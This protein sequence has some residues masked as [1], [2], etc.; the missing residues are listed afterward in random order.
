MAEHDPTQTET[1]AAGG[2][3]ETYKTTN[4]G[5][6]LTRY[7]PRNFDE[8][9]RL[10]NAVVRS[11]LAPSS[12]NRAEDAMIILMSGAELG[13]TAMQ[14]LRSI[15]VIKGRP[16]LSADLMVALVRR[17]PS[18]EF[19][20]LIELTNDRCVYETKRVEARTSVT[21][22]FS[23]DDA[24]RAG[25]LNNDNWKK[26]PRNMLRARCASSLARAEYPE[27]LTGVYDPDELAEPAAP[28]NTRPAR[29]T[30]APR[31]EDAIDAE[32]E[33]VDNAQPSEEHA[34]PKPAPVDH[35]GDEHWQQA[36]RRLHALLSHCGLGKDAP[37]RV[38]EM[39]KGTMGVE[40]FNH[41]APNYLG[42]VVGKLSKLSGDE[43]P[44]GELS[45]RAAHVIAALQKFDGQRPPAPEP[46]PEL[47]NED[48]EAVEVS[49]EE[50]NAVL[51]EPPAAA[52][53]SN[54]EARAT[55]EEIADL[56]DEVVFKRDGM[57]FLDAIA[58]NSGVDDWRN[59]SAAAAGRYRDMLHGLGTEPP[60][61]SR[62]GT[63]SP[64]AKYIHDIID[65]QAN[66]NRRAS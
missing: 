50:L 32:F 36:N 12:V 18:C 47:A 46:E 51:E 5:E 57:A 39:L 4:R 8:L 52:P 64:R 2:E 9:A 49:P 61:G 33:P 55:L 26:Y 27:L 37:G 53:Q 60:Q 44:D 25:L 48:A 20:D 7:E 23:M 10:S 40:S 59:L 58:A 11:G 42:A 66:A 19:F 21:F 31:Q 30:A 43:G 62:A 6:F 15:H 1:P 65:E 3:L 63:P 54:T 16:V 13:L 35:S 28:Q 29:Q 41:L 14:S 56:V 22:E 24:K 17:S 34:E 45:P 38:R